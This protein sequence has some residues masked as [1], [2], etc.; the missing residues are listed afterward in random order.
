MHQQIEGAGHSQM[1]GGPTVQSVKIGYSLFDETNDLSIHDRAAFDAS[2]FL[3]NARIA[4]RPVGA[5]H[6]E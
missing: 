4:F 5:I 1:I 6:R 2:S 3:H